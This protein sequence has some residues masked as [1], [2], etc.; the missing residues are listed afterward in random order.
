MVS[1]LILSFRFGHGSIEI[2]HLQ[3]ICLIHGKNVRL[4]VT[5]WCR[6]CLTRIRSLGVFFGAFS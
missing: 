5:S 3:L 6:A 1:L 2:A 4:V